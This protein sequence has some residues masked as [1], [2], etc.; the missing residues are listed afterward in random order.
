[1][2]ELIPHTADVRVRIEASSLEELFRDAVRGLNAA[3]HAHGGGTAV[4]RTISVH[5]S[6][7]TTSLLVDFLN[8]VLHRAHVGAERF[9]EVRF[10]RFDELSLDAELTGV[11]PASFDEDVKAV[12]YHE[13]E[14]RLEEETWTTMLVFDI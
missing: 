4:R 7:D 2:F 3:M 5:D 9:E 11:T 8:E 6:A 10:T 12:T 13:A 14:I 1:M